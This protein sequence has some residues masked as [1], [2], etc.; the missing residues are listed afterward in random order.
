MGTGPFLSQ[1]VGR[2]SNG[3]RARPHRESYALLLLGW[4]KT[5]IPS[6]A[7]STHHYPFA[8]PRSHEAPHATDAANVAAFHAVAES[9]FHA[10]AESASASSACLAAGGEKKQGAERDDKAAA[11]VACFAEGGTPQRGGGG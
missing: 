11:V 2:W 10:V 7:G 6:A 8:G 4:A 9:A 5:F 3:E 1:A